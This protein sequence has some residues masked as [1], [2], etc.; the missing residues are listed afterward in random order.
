MPQDQIGEYNIGS[1]KVEEDFFELMLA[2]DPVTNN[3]RIVDAYQR[4]KRIHA[5]KKNNGAE[6]IE[7]VTTMYDLLAQIGVI[8]DDD[9]G[10]I[11]NIC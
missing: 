9:N 11:M 4:A 3:R 2:I 6:Y 7:S 10:I 1:K 5:S 8:K